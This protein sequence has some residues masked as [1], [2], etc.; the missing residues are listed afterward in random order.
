[1]KLVIDV[2]ANTGVSVEATGVPNIWGVRAFADES[3]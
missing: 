2:A 3:A 1:V